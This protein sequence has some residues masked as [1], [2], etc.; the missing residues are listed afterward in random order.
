MN[1]LVL[2]WWMVIGQL[3]SG[4]RF[5][6]LGALLTEPMTVDSL[7]LGEVTCLRL[8]RPDGS[9]EVCRV[10]GHS[11]AVH[12]LPFSA[13]S[14]IR[15]QAQAVRMACQEPETFRWLASNPEVSVLATL[16]TRFEVFEVHRLPPELGARGPLEGVFSQ[17]GHRHSR[18]ASPKSE[19]VVHLVRSQQGTAVVAGDAVG[20]VGQAAEVL[21]VVPLSGLTGARAFGIVVARDFSGNG[22]GD[23]Q[24]TMDLFRADKAGIARLEPGL[25]LGKSSWYRDVY[26]RPPERTTSCF[27]RVAFV[28]NGRLRTA[29][30]HCQ[31]SQNVTPT[32]W[33]LNEKDHW[34][35]C[36]D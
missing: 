22:S 9:G 25:P 11:S 27:L 35:H 29:L 13:A 1:A 12:C 19:E 34:E 20:L 18:V 32:T 21:S 6:G 24:L 23:V 3:D 7:D 16:A 15:T 10:S 33:C 8:L 14:V 30:D 5:A 36:A 28:N 4:Q 31:R 17:H 26:I 2:M